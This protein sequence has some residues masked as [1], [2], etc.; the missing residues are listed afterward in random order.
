MPPGRRQALSGAL[1]SVISFVNVRR[2]FGDRAILQDVTFEVREGE[3]FFV[4]GSSG[5]GKS[6]LI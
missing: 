5:V 2:S 3:V 4:I 6:V 1:A